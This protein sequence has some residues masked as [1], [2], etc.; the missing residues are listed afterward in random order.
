[1]PWDKVKDRDERYEV[2]TKKREAR[3]SIE[4][5]QIHAGVD[6]CLKKKERCR[7]LRFKVAKNR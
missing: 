1:V 3:K 2:S 5:A 6:S 7:E 4:P